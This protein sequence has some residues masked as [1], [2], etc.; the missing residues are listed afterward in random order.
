MNSI[1]SS[2]NLNVDLLGDAILELQEM[3]VG[4]LNNAHV[5]IFMLD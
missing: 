1:N 2:Q 4:V 3:F 5:N